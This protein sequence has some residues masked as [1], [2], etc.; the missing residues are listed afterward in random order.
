M[1]HQK[2]DI[3]TPH[4]D[5]ST[6]V[7][8]SAALTDLYPSSLPFSHAMADAP[9][10]SLCAI[11]HGA[12]P[13]YRCPR[14]RTRTCSLGCVKKH[15]AWSDCSGRRDQTAYVPLDRLR[16]AAGI[17]HD[18]NF[19][20]GIERAVERAEREIVDDRKLVDHHEVHPPPPVVRDKVVAER[21]PDGRMVRRRVRVMEPPPEQG[22]ARRHV[23]RERNVARRLQELDITAAV[24]AF[25]MERRRENKTRWDKAT[26]SICWQVEW[27]HVDTDFGEEEGGDSLSKVKPTRIVHA[28]LEGLTIS[29][30]FKD[31]LEWVKLHGPRRSRPTER[32]GKEAAELGET[33]KVE[34]WQ[35]TLSSKWTSR[36]PAARQDPETATWSLTSDSLAAAPAATHEPTA[37]KFYLSKPNTPANQPKA[38]IRLNSADT[39]AS[40]LSGR[41]ILE[42]PTIYAIAHSTKIPDGFSV[43][44]GQSPRR[45]RK[46][47]V[48]EHSKEEGRRTKNR[49]TKVGSEAANGA[50]KPLRKNSLGIDYESDSDEGGL[51]EGELEEGEIDEGELS[52][53]SL[54]AESLESPTS[55]SGTDSLSSESDMASGSDVDLEETGDLAA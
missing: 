41:E 21:L 31:S 16:T 14:C 19:L 51:E 39:L 6:S 52:E 4:R 33:A 53:E 54:E 47:E 18:Y 35:D 25:G 26:H 50:S 49:R 30:A 20:A 10:T 43:V 44:K 36:S 23:L 24:A 42:Y 22:R 34:P 38:L 32:G 27:L 48:V 45:K 40:V 7:P 8:K 2:L 11:C 17:D 13:K 12:A 46:L 37:T 15:K 29:E 3:A 55:S 5:A 9:L 1:V 28:A